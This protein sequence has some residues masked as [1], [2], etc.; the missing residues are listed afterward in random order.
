MPPQEVTYTNPTYAWEGDMFIGDPKGSR[1]SL[2]GL[3]RADNIADLKTSLGNFTELENTLKKH[4]GNK[5]YVKGMQDTI[6]TFVLS[7]EYIEGPGGTR[8]YAPDV[9]M[10]LDSMR[11]RNKPLLIILP[12]WEHGDGPAGTFEIWGSELPMAGD[13]T[14]KISCTAKP[15]AGAE[16]V[17]WFT[18]EA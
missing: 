18:P 17:E 15:Y 4:K 16:P 1:Q 10:I 3:L 8:V 14:Q 7:L 5:A 6:V 9:K 13:E 2:A 12:R 11:T